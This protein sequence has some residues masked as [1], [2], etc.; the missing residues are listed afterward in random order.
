[1]DGAADQ[2]G[3]GDEAALAEE[4]DGR[5]RVGGG[6][7]VAVAGGAEEVKAGDGAELGTEALGVCGV[8]EV[9]VLEGD[10]VPVEGTD[11]SGEELVLAEGVTEVEQ[12]DAG[13]GASSGPGGTGGK[14]LELGE[15]EAGEGSGVSDVGIG[16]SGGG[17]G[18]IGFVRYFSNSW[19]AL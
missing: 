15:L 11:G 1:M 17:T 8:G 3:V 14:S 12:Q 4:D 5:F 16:V 19:R 7:N 10:G 9:E 13:E 2:G 6:E 18:G